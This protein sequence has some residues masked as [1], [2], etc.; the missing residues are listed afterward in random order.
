MRAC[1]RNWRT[2][3]QKNPLTWPHPSHLSQTEREDAWCS[4]VLVGGECCR[5]SAEKKYKASCVI[6]CLCMSTVTSTA[7]FFLPTLTRSGAHRERAQQTQHQRKGVMLCVT[8]ALIN[9]A[10]SPFLASSQDQRVL[11]SLHR[12]RPPT[13]HQ[14]ESSSLVLSVSLVVLRASLLLLSSLSDSSGSGF[15]PISPQC[16]PQ[17]TLF[18]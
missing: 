12:R 16:S 5:A 10:H 7:M 11:S 13:L 18:F 8:F 3:Q 2:E 4:S 1:T 9:I 14:S 17:R 6:P 15:P